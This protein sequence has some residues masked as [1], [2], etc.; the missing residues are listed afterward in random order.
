[1]FGYN[2]Y[3]LNIVTVIILINIVIFLMI[4]SGK[5][6]VDKLGSSYYQVVKRQQYYR[7]IT[8]SFSHE[9][10]IHIICNM[11]SLYNI[12]YTIVSYFGTKRFVLIYLTSMLAGGLLSSYVHHY[13]KDDYTLSIGASGAI[14]GLLGC[15]FVLVFLLSYNKASAISYMLRSIVPML[16]TGLNPQ[17]DGIGHICGL[18]IGVICGLLIMLF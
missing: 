18:I 10:Y 16:I 12:G 11:Y 14:C 7:L 5:L 9:S 1:M 6:D 3:S 8:S 13:T 17:I 2:S 4:N 15:Y